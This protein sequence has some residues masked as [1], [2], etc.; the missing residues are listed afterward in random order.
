MKCPP[1]LWNVP[2]LYGKTLSDRSFL[3]GQSCHRERRKTDKNSPGKDCAAVALDDQ[4][5]VCE[6]ELVIRA[7]GNRCPDIRSSS[8]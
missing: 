3:D 4:K 6:M 2:I 1:L 8:R 7:H 5:R